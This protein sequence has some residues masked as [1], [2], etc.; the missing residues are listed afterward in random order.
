MIHKIWRVRVRSR[1]RTTSYHH[2]FKRRSCPTSCS[3][4]ALNPWAAA[5]AISRVHENYY[6]IDAVRLNDEHTVF[7]KTTSFKA[8]FSREL[9]IRYPSSR[10]ER[11]QLRIRSDPNKHKIVVRTSVGRHDTFSVRILL[12]GDWS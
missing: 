6:A 4:H 7:M 5:A 8:N 9:L 1:F 11:K 12:R 3:L 2:S 10:P